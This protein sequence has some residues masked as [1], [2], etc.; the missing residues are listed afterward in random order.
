VVSVSQKRIR[1][2]RQVLME[3]GLYRLDG[4]IACKQ[5]LGKAYRDEA[6]GR[7]SMTKE[8]FDSAMRGIIA[9]R[10]MSVDTQRTLS[11]MLGEIFS[12]FDHDGTRT[13]NAV[14]VACGFTVLCKG[15][16]SDKL[17][18][19]F[20]VLDRDRRGNLARSDT[21]R[22]LRS[23]LT[24]LLNIVSTNTLDSDYHEDTMTTTSGMRCERTVATM[25][26]AV[27]AGSSWAAAQAFRNRR[28]SHD[29]ICFDEFAEWYTQVGYSNIPWLE[30]L[31]LQKWVVTEI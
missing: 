3:S 22:Y 19:A 10:N 8:D 17:E 21:A 15:K 26:R 30:L 25:A 31:D 2:L 11:D 28:G 4:E 6:T 23:F 5:I 13:V 20:E 27:E 24:V 12:A 16:K 14:E 29:L 7:Y 1:H 18:Y 9:S